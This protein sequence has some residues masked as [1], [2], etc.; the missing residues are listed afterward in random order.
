[1]L[2]RSAY[3]VGAFDTKGVELTFIARELQKLGLKAITV[4]LATSGRPSAA[5]IG[6]AEV[7]RHHPGGAKAVFTGDRGSAVTAMATAFEHFIVKRKDVGGVIS[8][9]G[10]GGTALATPGM[11]ALTIGVPK[12]MVSTVASGDVGRYVGA[13]D[14]SM[15]YS[16]TDVQGIN[17]I[18]EQVLANAAHALGGMILHKQRDGD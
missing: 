16:V 8:A 15:M 5:N 4:D 18:S 17:R 11:R 12:F 6:P 7:A 10:S 13:S 3:V 9:G 2:G 14:I 1:M